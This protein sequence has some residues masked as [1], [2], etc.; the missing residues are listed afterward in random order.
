M[1][2]HTFEAA[3]ARIVTELGQLIDIHVHITRHEEIDLAVAIIV[4]PGCA[5]AE[6]SRA[7]SSLVGYVFKFAVAKVVIQRVAAE[8][9]DVDILQAVVVVVGY[10]DAH[11]PAFAREAGLLSDVGEL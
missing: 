4:C 9:G 8:A 5:G 1:H 3:E 7:D 10:G 2:Q 11:A 6:A